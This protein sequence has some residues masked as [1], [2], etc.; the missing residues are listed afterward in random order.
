MFYFSLKSNPEGRR[1]AAQ[2][3][4]WATLYRVYGVKRVGKSREKALTASKTELY[5]QL[6]ISQPRPQTTDSTTATTFT[7]VRPGGCLT[8]PD[9]VR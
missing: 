4:Q 6:F 7:T 9:P 8:P 3:R 1:A 5:Q 2:G